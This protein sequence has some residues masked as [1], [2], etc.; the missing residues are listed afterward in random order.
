MH[1]VKQYNKNACFGACLES[2]LRDLG[3]NFSH[4]QFIKNNL[5][6]FNG[7]TDKEGSCSPLSFQEIAKRLRLKHSK[8]FP[9][10][11]PVFLIVFWNNSKSDVHCVRFSHIEN[12]YLQIMNPKTPIKLER[13][14][15]IWIQSIHKFTQP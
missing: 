7:G 4:E 15:K 6:L 9:T 5:D 1:L 2:F 13:I 11:L 10:K 12:K 8:Y 3:Q 14:P